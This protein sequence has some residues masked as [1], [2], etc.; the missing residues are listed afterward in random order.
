[1]PLPA[2]TLVF[3]ALIASATSPA[4]A[5]LFASAVATDGVSPAVIVPVSASIV[6]VSFA[7]F[8]VAVIPLRP[9]T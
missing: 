4:F 3:A 8:T 1:M 5:S 2:T 6:N 7:L 9:I